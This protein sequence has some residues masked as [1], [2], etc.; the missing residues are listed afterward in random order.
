MADYLQREQA[1]LS[2]G[3]WTALD[4]AVVQTARTTLVG[5]RFIAL[6][7]PLGAGVEAVPS[8]ALSGGAAGQVDLLG[9][10]ENEAIGV[11]RRRYLPLPLIYKDFWVHWRDLESN[12]QLGLP[13][14]TSR[15]AGAAAACA[16][17]E[18]RLVFE[19]E[20]GLGITGLR[21][22]EGRLARTIGD[23]GTAGRAFDDVVEGVR[24]LTESGFTGPYA[25]ALSPR[26][27]AQLHRIYDNS[28]VLEI[29]QIE[30]LARR[31]VFPTS[32]VPETSALLVDSSP[33]NLDL[34][35]AVDLSTAFVEST[36]LNYRMRVVE[37]LV[38]RVHRPGAICA[39]G[40]A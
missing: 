29:E 39:F 4:E 26:L 24:L 14:D 38:P 31:G 20:P 2:S 12:R 10:V 7:G 1:P 22:V 6:V 28:G 3:Q 9:N 19:G 16:V 32:V 27:Y 40:A 36:N 18:D 11:E 34:A 17:A 37:S 30:K 5:R 33:Q 25:L 23:W 15:A 35:V 8:D 21:T 13:L